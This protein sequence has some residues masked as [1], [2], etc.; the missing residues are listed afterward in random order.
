MN[1]LPKY[2]K[3][4][5]LFSAT[6]P[7]NRQA[8]KVADYVSLREENKGSMLQLDKDLIEIIPLFKY[9]L[10]LPRY[11]FDVCDANALVIGKA[12]DVP[13]DIVFCPEQ[14][15]GELLE[16]VSFDLVLCADS[17]FSSVN[18]IIREKGLA[19]EC[20][21]AKDLNDE[22]LKSHWRFLLEKRSSNGLRPV[23]DLELQFLLDDERLLFLPMLFVGRQYGQA[24]EVYK[25]AFNSNNIFEDAAN[26]LLLQTCRH[27][28][29]M[30]C[31]ESADE[32]E[33]IKKYNDGFEY[34]K[35]KG[36]LINLVITYPGVPGNQVKYAGL[37][38]EL[39]K[40]E[41]D[42]LRIIGVHRAIAKKGLLMELATVDRRLF[43]KLNELEI[44]INASPRA[45]NRFVYKAIRDLGN[46]LRSEFSRIQMWVLARS[47]QIS[48]FSNF[49]LGIFVPDGSDVP[50]QCLKE[51]SFRAASPLTRGLQIEM[52]KHPQIYLGY[53]CRVLFIECVPD[54]PANKFIRECSR[55]IVHSLEESAQSNPKFSFRCEE[56]FCVKDLLGILRN[57]YFEY[58]MLILSAHGFC[59]RERNISGLVIGEEKWMAAD[60]NFFVPPIVLLSACHVSPRGSGAISA[61]DIF[62]RARAEAVL[63]SFISIDAHRNAILITRLL[64]YIVAAQSGSKQYRTLLEAWA[65]IVASN[66]I[67]EMAK[68]SNAFNQWL[69]E[70]N[71]DGISR[72]ADF[73]NNRSVARL[74]IKTIYRDT[75]AIVKE[76]LRDEGI[77]GKFANILDRRDY[78]PESFFYQW[79]GFPENVF[80]Y[81][82]DF[83][84]AIKTNSSSDSVS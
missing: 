66:T 36:A 8:I 12:H 51:V 67:L 40:E 58:D 84:A 4:L 27:D 61:A 82:E 52:T 2:Y 45:N 62:L 50:L 72:F 31:K 64:S 75:V 59:E 60:N 35:A 53:K 46:Q 42:I 11:E 69:W 34:A 24:S 38:R 68:E 47:K 48:I 37:S 73:A 44:S 30:N 23:K 5:I 83:E 32:E 70:D 56:A 71:V 10:H 26:M 41:K 79:I 65:G 7:A 77:E 63:S 17:C 81:N 9:C 22:T 28:A 18:A 6:S 54:Y 25:A 29:L 39:P 76:M 3:Y 49:P 1:Q 21:Q 20:V 74:N 19:L 78:F 57:S 33:F 13:H 16:H 43:E 80:V 14:A 15:F 55:L